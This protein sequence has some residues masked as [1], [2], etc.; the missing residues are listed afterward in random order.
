VRE[1]ERRT[2]QERREE[3]WPAWSQHHERQRRRLFQRMRDLLGQFQRQR[4]QQRQQERSHR[5]ERDVRKESDLWHLWE[6]SQTHW[7]QN[8]F[9][10][11]E[12]AASEE[13]RERRRREGED[14]G[15]VREEREWEGVPEWDRHDE[16]SQQCD[17][18][19]PKV[20]HRKSK[21]YAKREQWSSQTQ[22]EMQRQRDQQPQQQRSQR[23]EC[24][25]RR[26]EGVSS[27][28][29]SSDEVHRHLWG[30][31]Q[32]LPS[33]PFAGTWD[34]ESEWEWR[35]QGKKRGRCYSMKWV[36]RN[37]S[38]SMRWI[39]LCI[40]LYLEGEGETVLL[41]SETEAVAVVGV[42]DTRG[43]RGEDIGTLELL[44]VI[45]F[46]FVPLFSNSLR[47]LTP[48]NRVASSTSSRGNWQQKR[49]GQREESEER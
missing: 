9:P 19:C 5:Q 38:E 4:E 1:W 43:R 14:R 36:Q 27:H 10:V 49:E 33:T 13:R 16:Y 22:R 48:P 21:L 6:S 39:Q 37:P 30:S 20:D 42:E 29:R 45:M 17:W 2:R 34:T 41:L 25:R 12:G 35:G 40:W 7:L 32:I 11:R 44:L 47:V 8:G 31:N 28:E 18:L 26:V 46:S 23:R 3:R 15:D 24:E